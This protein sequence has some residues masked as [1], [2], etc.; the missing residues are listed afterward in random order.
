MKIDHCSRVA[1]YGETNEWTDVAKL[2]GVFLQL[3]IVRET[4][5]EI[6]DGVK[7]RINSGNYCQC[8]VK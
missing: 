8:S 7:R 2:L 6:N 5:Y 4:K 1:T 3:F